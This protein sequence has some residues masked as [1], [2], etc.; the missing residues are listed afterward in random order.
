ML[1]DTRIESESKWVTMSLPKALSSSTVAKLRDE[2]GSLSRDGETKR[3]IAYVKFP[4]NGGM[5]LTERRWR[6]AASRRY[7]EI[8]PFA[9]GILVE[10][11]PYGEAYLTSSK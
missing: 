6:A 1:T 7:C 8:R 5:T 3:L 4:K 10:L 11:T 2:A 9:G